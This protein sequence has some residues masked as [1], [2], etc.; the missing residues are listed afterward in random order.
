MLMKT[1]HLT[2][3]IFFSVDNVPI[4]KFVKETDPH[5]TRKL[6]ILQ[7]CQ[8]I[9]APF[10]CIVSCIFSVLKITWHKY[11]NSDFSIWIL[12][13]RTLE[14]LCTS[15]LNTPPYFNEIIFYMYKT[16]YTVLCK[17]ASE[18]YVNRNSSK[19]H[20]YTSVSNAP[21]TKLI[22]LIWLEFHS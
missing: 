5:W 10:H 12:A 2:Q 8:N 9:K 20:F 11:M 22:T 19:T 3:G 4:C 21:L 17:F 18:T 15:I 1:R 7:F 6:N 14:Y 16:Y 13:P